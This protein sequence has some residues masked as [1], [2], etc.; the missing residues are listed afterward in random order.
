MSDVVIDD[1]LQP[2]TLATVANGRLE[3]Q[4][5]ERLF[6]TL[7]VLRDHLRLQPESDGKFRCEIKL[8]I[9]IVFDPSD[10][11]YVQEARALHT[12]KPKPRFADADAYRRSDGLKVLPPM[13][14]TEI[15]A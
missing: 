14:Q 10:G 1:E 2:M 8:E 13:V 5:Q 3:S 11:T 9:G 4:F 6:E 7:E 15:P 12:K